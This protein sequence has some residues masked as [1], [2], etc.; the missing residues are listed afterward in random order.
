M[1][2]RRT[3]IRRVQHALA[4]I[5]LPAAMVGCAQPPP[6]VSVEARREVLSLL[7]PDRINIVKSFTRAARFNSEDRADG[8]EL[9]VQAVNKFDDPGLMIVGT[10]RVELFEH[11]PASG[12]H[13]GQRHENWDIDLSTSRHQ[14]SY[15]NGLTQMYE[16]RLGINPK[17]IPPADRYILAVTYV[18]PFDERLSDEFVVDFRESALRPASFRARP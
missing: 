9:F 3:A 2:N 7:M 5:A 14:E 11:I 16:F 17:T 10:V 18:S 15:W 12:D 13:R 1:N 6:P 8:I 4:Y